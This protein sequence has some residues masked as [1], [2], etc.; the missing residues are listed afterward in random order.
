MEI[1]M[2]TVIHDD[3]PRIRQHSADVNIPLSKE[4]AEL[5]FKMHQYVAE[6]QDEQIAEVKNLQPAVGIAA[7]QLGIPKK[8]IAVVVPIDED[9]IFEFAL[10]NPKIISRSRELAALQTGEGCLSVPET[11]EG[12]VF[13]SNR[14]KVRGYDLLTDQEVTIKAEGYPA[15]VLQHEIDHLSGKLYYDHINQ[16]NPYQIPDNAVVLE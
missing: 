10:A 15:I 5:L 12:Y 7:I 1:N 4:D 14:I 13:R 9:H 3:D 2:E 6:S 16:K 8:M 11:K